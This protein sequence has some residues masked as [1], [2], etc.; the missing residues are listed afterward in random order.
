ME[1][2]HTR[3]LALF[4]A[5]AALAACGGSDAVIQSPIGGD[6]IPLAQEQQV[7]VRYDYDGDGNPDH[8]TLDTTKTPYTIVEALGGTAAG[9]P[10]D[11]TGALK[12]QPIDSA[13]SDALATYMAG[14]LGVASEVALDVTDTGGRE[15]TVTIYE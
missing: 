8:L 15:L 14:S 7:V 1:I 11:M 9:V 3:H 4:L 10:L 12:D 2:M 13:I 6:V 5:L